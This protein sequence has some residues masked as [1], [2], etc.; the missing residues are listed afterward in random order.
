MSDSTQ[1]SKAENVSEREKFC[2]DL[3]IRC[4]QSEVVPQ[5]LHDKGAVLVGFFSQGVELSN[6]FFKCLTR[7]TVKV[8]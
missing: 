6:S 7:S 3:D 1:T 2:I 8:G 4:P 5:E